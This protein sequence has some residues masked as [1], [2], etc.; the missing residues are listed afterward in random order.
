MELVLEDT[1]PSGKGIEPQCAGCLIKIH[2]LEVDAG[3]VRISANEFTIGRD[4]ANHLPLRDDSVS[5][6]HAKIVL[7]ESAYYVTDLD[8]TNGVYVNEEP[9]QHCELRAG[10]RLRLGNQ[11]FKFLDELE[12]QY[13]ETAYDMLT[14]DGLTGA[15]NKRHFMEAL[16]RNVQRCRRRRLPMALVLF[17]ID[18]F[19]RINDTYGHLAGDEVLQELSARVMQI[20]RE[21]ELFARLG[22]EEFA[23][24]NCDGDLNEA[25]Q[26]AERCRSLMGATP[27]ETSAGAIAVTIS[28]GVAQYDLESSAGELIARADRKLYQAKRAGRNQICY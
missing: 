14:R 17:D 8:S 21:D 13:H 26:F 10:D 9:V 2:P 23:I 7:G 20:A 15:Y 3:V 12:A 6:C 4:E 28:G 11:I 16:D 5:R 27:F 19:K 24:L 22:G 1:A 25:V 18:H